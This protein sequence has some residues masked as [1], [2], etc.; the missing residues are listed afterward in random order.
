MF[1]FNT[2]A[3][4]GF[5]SVVLQGCAEDESEKTDDDGTPV[6]AYEGDNDGECSDGVDNDRNSLFDCDDPGCAGAPDCASTGEGEGE[7]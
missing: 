4:V 2:L 7:G 1:K 5:V 6:D 3:A